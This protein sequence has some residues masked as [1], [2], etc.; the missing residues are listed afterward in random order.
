MRDPEDRRYVIN[1][2][3]PG[4]EWV[5]SWE[6]LATRKYDGTCV[7]FDGRAWWAR[8]EVKTGKQR[9]DH[10]IPVQYDAVTGKT[11]GWQPIGQ[12]SFH[13][14][15]VEALESVASWKWDV[16][17]YELIGPKI[18]GNPERAG[19]HRLVRHGEH[20]EPTVTFDGR[21]PTP[22]DFGGLR[23]FLAASN[24][25]DD[26]TEGIVFWRDIS[27]PACDKAKIKARDF[28]K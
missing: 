12:S 24:E 3:T 15:F 9:P 19:G 14:Y 10:F 4:C 20:R 16:A 27:D 1:E 26:F 7:M 6:G 17:T 18:N 23:D 25:G 22:R 21:G 8:R 2:V 13:R 28:R 11:V 5:L